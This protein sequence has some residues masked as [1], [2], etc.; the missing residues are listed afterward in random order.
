[1]KRTHFMVVIMVLIGALF[2]ATLPALAESVTSDGIANWWQMRSDKATSVCEGASPRMLEACLADFLANA[3]AGG[4]SIDS[5]DPNDVTAITG[6][7]SCPGSGYPNEYCGNA[8]GNSVSINI[9]DVTI[10]GGIHS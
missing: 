10:E 9:S 4:P 2:L 5:Y 8:S 3:V 1:M 7:G 6:L